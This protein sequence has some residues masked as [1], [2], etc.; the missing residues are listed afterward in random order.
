M[1]ATTVDGRPA[2]TV[3]GM[4]G[5]TLDGTSAVTVVGYGPAAHRLVQRLH[6]H[7]QR[8]PVT[9]FGAEPDPAY[10]RGQLVSVLDGTLPA[11][12]LTLA[13]LPPGVRIRTGSRIV[14]VDPRRRLVRSD[15]GT[16][17]PYGILVLAS[18]SR[19]VLPR[20]AGGA[21]ERS[22]PDIR[23]PHTLL[24]ARPVVRGPVVVVGGGLRGTETAYALGRAGHDV[25]LVH[26][27]AHPMHRLLD[28]RAG[29]L[30]T[31]MLREAGVVVETGRRVV[32]VEPGKIVLDDVRPLAAGTLL[33]CT[34]TE[35]DTGLARTAG[36][37]VSDGIVVGDRLRTSD[38]YIHALGDCVQQRPGHHSTL[39]S[40][41]DQADALA[42]TLCG[43]DGRLRPARHPVVRP[44]LPALAILGPPGALDAPGDDEQVVLSDPAGGRYGRLVLRDGRVHAGI[45]VGL[46]RAVATVGRLYAEDRPLPPDRLALLLGT[47]EEYA[48]SGA[49]PDTAVVC[50]CNNVTRKDLERAWGQGA[51]DLPAIA[52]ATRATTGCGS[53]TEVV[54]RICET[55]LRDGSGND[56]PGVAGAGDPVAEGTGA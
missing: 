46:D 49:L 47:D 20:L 26:P 42:R 35:P 37:A 56:R 23:V 19:P 52:V 6:H 54:R 12:A 13:P 28:A 4:S 50:Q 53:C 10:H 1:T 22:T 18:G 51:R 33:L 5:P 41:W 55:D 16:E 17:H 44:R 27:G 39:T 36:L 8:G 48:S 32:A 34:G 45:L 11:D 43:G 24:G 3:D 30:V 29:G 9:V 25:T 38:P 31:A 40:A 21:G 7:G 2:I 14:A 15:D